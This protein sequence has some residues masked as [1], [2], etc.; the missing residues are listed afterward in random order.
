M[1]FPPVGGLRGGGRGVE[2]TMTRT[3]IWLNN[4][5]S[6]CHLVKM[7]I[8]RNGPWLKSRR[9]PITFPCGDLGVSGLRWSWVA[10]SQ[11]GFLCRQE[12]TKSS[13]GRPRGRRNRTQ[14]RSGTPSAGFR[15]S[16]A[17][18]KQVNSKE[19]NIS[20]LRVGAAEVARRTLR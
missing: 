11:W 12:E 14:G 20:C 2:T 18:E 13:E 8:G 9:R 19:V 16:G 15:L 5:D 7:A 4:H 1:Q 3:A 17:G 6:G 10:V